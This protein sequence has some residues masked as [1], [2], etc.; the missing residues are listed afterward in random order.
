MTSMRRSVRLALP[1]LA[2]AALAA[3]GGGARDSGGM[4]SGERGSA[5]NALDQLQ[6]TAIPT[7]LVQVSNT[8]GAIPRVCQ[9]H[10][11][12]DGTYDL[13]V[14]WRPFDPRQAYAWL[15]GNVTKTWTKD[16]F[17]VGYDS[18]SGVGRKL[19]QRTQ[20]DAFTKPHAACQL[21]TDGMVRLLPAAK[22]GSS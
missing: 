16:H 19:Q 1:M 5:Q 6:R 8:A 18:G 10:V 21:L 22:T 3:C 11:R 2:V 12:G 17:H 4:T 14:F 20:G 7:T 15:Q 13:F 9:V